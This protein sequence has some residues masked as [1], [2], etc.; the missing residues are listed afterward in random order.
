L[1]NLRTRSPVGLASIGKPRL[2]IRVKLVSF[3]ST[4]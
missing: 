1:R 3:Y 4:R 2:R